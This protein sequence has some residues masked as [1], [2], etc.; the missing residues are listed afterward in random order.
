[1]YTIDEFILRLQS[2]RDLSPAGGKTPM[3]IEDGTGGLAV[4]AVELRPAMEIMERR[5]WQTRD[6]GN[7]THVL[8][9]F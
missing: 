8:C 9:V 5:E 2:L 4:A 7:D 3:V 6:E 1:M